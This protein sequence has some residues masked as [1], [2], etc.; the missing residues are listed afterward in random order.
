MRNLQDILNSY[1][2][3]RYKNIRILKGGAQPSRHISFAQGLEILQGHIYM[4]VA[5]CLMLTHPKGRQRIHGATE[6][7]SNRQQ[8]II[9]T[10]RV[11]S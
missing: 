2:E 9:I 3:I 1:S 11:K 5:L 4:S 8:F 6:S 7:R 10:V